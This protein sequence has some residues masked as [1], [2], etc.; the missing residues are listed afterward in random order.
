MRLFTSTLDTKKNTF[1]LPNKNGALSRLRTRFFHQNDECRQDLLYT[2]YNSRWTFWN[3]NYRCDLLGKCS[4]CRLQFNGSLFFLRKKITKSHCVSINSRRNTEP[5]HIEHNR[6]DIC[7]FSQAKQIV[8]YCFSTKPK[9]LVAAWLIM[10][11][12]KFAAKNDFYLD[13]YIIKF[14]HQWQQST[15]GFNSRKSLN[16]LFSSDSFIINNLISLKCKYLVVYFNFRIFWDAYLGG[17][18]CTKNF[19]KKY[20]L[21]IAR[22]NGCIQ[23]NIRTDDNSR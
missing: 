13:V 22:Y 10:M 16:V 1:N 5:M 9:A 3:P 4:I 19:M 18:D 15:K 17:F 8:F 14:L 20:W 7:R 11:T 2:L 21:F 6:F 23:N 12:A